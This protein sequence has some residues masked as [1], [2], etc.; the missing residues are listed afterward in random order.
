MIT[1][2]RLGGST[3]LS[4]DV[5]DDAAPTVERRAAGKRSL[6][7]ADVEAVAPG[8]LTR[9]DTDP[10]ALTPAAAL[11][12]ARA[13][14]RKAEPGADVPDDGALASAFAF[15]DGGRG[16]RRLPEA[17]LR[18]LARQL[19]ADLGDLRVHTDRTAARAAAAI[20]A[21]AFTIGSD[22][23]F[24][25]GAYD[26]TSDAGIELIAHEAAHVVRNQRGGRSRG[27]SRPDDAHEREADAFAHAFVRDDAV[28]AVLRGDLLTIS[29]VLAL[30]T[31]QLDIVVDALPG[32]RGMQLGATVYL[33]PAVI[34]AGGEAARYVLAHELVHVAQ[35]ALPQRPGLDY[36]AAEAEAASLGR[37]YAQGQGLARPHVGL[38]SH[39]VARDEGGR[40]D[41]AK[42][43]ASPPPLVRSVGLFAVTYKPATVA[44]WVGGIDKKRQAL[45]AVLQDLVG[46]SAYSVELLD[47]VI[48][49]YGGS[50][51]FVASGTI[52]GKATQDDA[53]GQFTVQ[54]PLMLEL[55][56]I[57]TD[58]GLKVS[59]TKANIETLQGGIDATE[60]WEDFKSYVPDWMTKSLYAALIG[61]TAKTVLT[62]YAQALR[63]NNDKGGAAAE[64]ELVDA[65]QAAIDAIGMPIDVLEAVRGDKQLVKEPA[66]RVLWDLPAVADTKGADVG[67]AAYDRPPAPASAFYFLSDQLVDK[68][69]A[70]QALESHDARKKVL[71]R[72]GTRLALRAL[73]TDGDAVLHDGVSKPQRPPLGS[74]LTTYPQLEPP[75]FDTPKGGDREFVMSVEFPDVFEAF[76][77]YVYKWELIHVP[78]DAIEKL[79]Q[80]ADDMS[81]HGTSPD[82][83]D[84]LGGRL[85]RDVEYG[86][87]DIRRAIGALRSQLGEPGIGVVTLAAV[88]AALRMVGTVLKTFIETLFKPRYEKTLPFDKDGLYVVRCI[89]WPQP[90]DKSVIDRAPSVAW[91]PIWVRPARDMAKLR[92]NLD[93]KIRLGGIDR[94]KEITEQLK[95]PALKPEVRDALKEEYRGIEVSLH[96]TGD[97]VLVLEKRQLETALKTAPAGFQQEQIKKRIAEIEEVQKMRT[98]RIAGATTD[99]SLE[100]LTRI[101]A[102]FVAD[103]SQ[104]IRPLF[105][106][107][108][109]PNS[110]TQVVYHAIDSTTKNSGHRDG[111]GATREDAIANGIQNILESDQGYGRGYVTITIPATPGTPGAQ[112]AQRTIRIEKSLGGII[113]EAVDNL[114]TVAAIAAVAAAPFTGGASLALLVPIG[115]VG[116]IPS[117]YRLIDRGQQG[118]LRFDMAT[119]MDIVNILGAAVGAGQASAAGKAALR[120]VQLGR[121]W[122]ILGLGTDGLGMLVAGAGV[123]DQINELSKDPNMP[124]GLRNAMI[125]QIVGNQLVQLGMMVGATLS[126]HGKAQQEALGGKKPVEVT[127]AP[128]EPAI[129]EKFR[130][131][132][133]PKGKEITVYRDTEGK[134]VVGAGVEVQFT[135][136]G[137]HLPTDIKVVAGPG[138]SEKEILGHAKTA[139]A[140][141][142]HQG[143]IGYLRNLLDRLVLALKGKSEPKK[144]SRAWE[145]QQE[146]NKLPDLIYGVYED[147]KAGKITEEAAASKMKDLQAQMLRYEQAVTELGEGKGFIASHDNVTKAAIDKGY[148][149]PPKD[150]FYYET[151][152]GNYQLQRAVDSTEPPWHV[153]NHNGKWV[154]VAGEAPRAAGPDVTMLKKSLADRLGVAADKVTLHG[155]A[156]AADPAVKVNPDGSYEIHYKQGTPEDVLLKAA[157]HAKEAGA[158][159]RWLLDLKNQLP[160]DQKRQLELMTKGKTPDEIFTMFSGD[161]DVALA[162]IGGSNL[163]NDLIQ[164]RG[165]LG[166]KARRAFD[167]KWGK[168]IGGD[169]APS[170][171]KIKAFREFLDGMEKRGGGNLEKGLEDNV[172]IKTGEKVTDPKADPYPPTW[173][174]FDETNNEAFKKRLEDFRGTDDLDNSLRGGEGR[175]YPDESRTKALKRWFKKR[176]GDFAASIKLLKDAKVAVEALPDLAKLIDI[177]TV[178]EVEKDWILRDFVGDS[179]AIGHMPD[180][181]PSRLAAIAAI[182]AVKPPRDPILD[183]LR[184]KLADKSENIHWSPGRGKIVVIDM[185]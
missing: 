35:R 126:A 61:F 169:R 51:R 150:H 46:K 50:D 48:A 165:K 146:L 157:D 112:P 17:L 4:R 89:S 156:T 178:Y 109:K 23:Y 83:L 177:V 103:S 33:D 70:K 21:R 152:D 148:P 13:I 111:E 20:N 163:P 132:V 37:A 173:E 129:Q 104:T 79:N 19:R 166:E 139:R 125:A 43:L 2:E 181:E 124:P 154:L 44:K 27:V 85:S 60:T 29:Q 144:G 22:I 10:Y 14:D 75:F 94:L 53:V 95:D 97:D 176:L 183:K 101:P 74:T 63:V 134:Q 119:A 24:A 12:Y 3:R 11:R 158:S 118:T 161:I 84:V 162:K 155:D 80:T 120:G 78:D 122:M 52:D 8:K 91:L 81:Q 117:A 123:M 179:D 42:L 16:G 28:G 65:R 41:D 73:P 26:P 127:H 39:Q 90:S 64:K 131:E 40:G 15:L 135:K 100:A 58:K 107:Y 32:V 140:L 110:G 172:K 76:R 128:I 171:E 185:Q 142:E 116:A 1:R 93:D 25:D 96:G 151:S 147:L 174:S 106:V 145:A 105:E 137:Y 138:A 149:T 54:G 31:G 175:V 59:L 164:L 99:G 141:L 167:Y 45:A 168:M 56:K 102:A 62:R 82:Q 71:D 47:Q 184:G 57:L 49:V 9:L 170:A 88:G 6:L 87:A 180:S 114:A 72:F 67:V 153:E 38:A 5:D 18:R 113:E 108:Q 92:A 86:N 159:D 160:P 66:Y 7:D 69:L 143:L 115:I 68:A 182:D 121:G 98:S 133:G 77:G 34:A 130:A 30:D 36:M 136:D 55:V